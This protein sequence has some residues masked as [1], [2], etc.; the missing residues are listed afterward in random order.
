[1]KLCKMT[2]IYIWHTDINNA[3]FIQFLCYQI[4]VVKKIRGMFNYMI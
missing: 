2:I 1:M 4:H 3:I